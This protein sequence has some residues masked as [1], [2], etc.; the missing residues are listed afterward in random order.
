VIILLGNPGFIEWYRQFLSEIHSRHRSQVAILAHA[1]LGHSPDL[2][3]V[4]ESSCGL[5]AQV[6]NAIEAY[7]AVAKHFPKSRIVLLGHSIGSWIILQV[8]Y[9]IINE[10]AS[11]AQFCND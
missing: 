7:D 3:A 2:P 6:E 5:L 9:R 4:P 10:P 11:Q 8:R 1:N